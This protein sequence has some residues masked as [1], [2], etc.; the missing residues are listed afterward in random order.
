MPRKK[1]YLSCL[2][3]F[4]CCLVSCSLTKTTVT[5]IW[6]DDSYQGGTL[7][8][9]LVIGAAERQVLRKSFEDEMVKGLRDEGNKI[10]A[11][12]QVLPFDK[13]LDE[14]TILA[15][16]NELQIDGVLITRVLSKA[17]GDLSA[18]EESKDWHNF[19][20]RSY[21][22]YEAGSSSALYGPK[23][24]SATLQT[25]LYEAKGEKLIWSAS[26]EVITKTEPE[27]ALRAVIKVIV[28]ELD[29]TGLIR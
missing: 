23:T 19:Y 16:V 18:P 24:M 22:G 13:M 10:V 26:Q 28:Q 17:Y 6:Q 11:S 5:D 4:F 7:K 25:N 9:I 21:G 1:A 15:K 3:V 29:K 12:Y 14:E 8:N 2:A 27:K 20:A